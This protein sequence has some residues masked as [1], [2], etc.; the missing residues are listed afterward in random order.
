MSHLDTQIYDQFQ[1]FRI[2]NTV[3]HKNNALN[4]NPW[5][6]TLTCATRLTTNPRIM[7]FGYSPAKKGKTR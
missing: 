6:L 2:C 3:A 1:H 4:K 7:D 5:E